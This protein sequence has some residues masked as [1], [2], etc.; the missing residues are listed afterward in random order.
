MF[1]SVSQFILGDYP[2]CEKHGVINSSH[3]YRYEITQ[4]LKEEFNT[5]PTF[6]SG[7]ALL[8]V[9]EKYYTLQK[10]VIDCINLQVPSTFQKYRKNIGTRQ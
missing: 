2:R 3:T 1:V 9:Y 6:V 8:C 5:P 4:S 7:V 10:A